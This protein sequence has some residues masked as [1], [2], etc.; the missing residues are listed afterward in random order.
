MP[1]IFKDVAFLLSVFSLVGSIGFQIYHFYISG[2][3]IFFAFFIE[4]GLLVVFIASLT[5]SIIF[6]HK[7]KKNF[8]NKVFIPLLI[9]VLTFLTVV[10]VPFTDIAIRRNFTAN[11][12]AREEVIR[13]INSGQ[14]KPNVPHNKM[15]I[16][17]PDKYTGLSSGGGDVKFAD[18]Q[19]GTAVFFYTFRGILDNYSGFAY[20]PSE[21]VDCTKHFAYENDI[22][23]VE[24]ID[25]N[26]YWLASH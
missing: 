22:M 18:T 17:L 19:E 1:K 14:I 5:V 8:G 23:Q 24:K 12:G 13:S 7:H 20:C 2:V 11:K 15:L 4:L 25:K 9:N 26:W 21:K 6:A 16:H 10:F 3:M